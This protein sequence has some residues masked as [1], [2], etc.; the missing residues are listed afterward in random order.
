LAPF[1]IRVNM[2]AIGSLTAIIFSSYLASC[3]WSLATGEL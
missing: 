2:S 3:F 1:R